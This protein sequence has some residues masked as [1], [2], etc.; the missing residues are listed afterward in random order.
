MPDLWIIFRPTT[1]FI[2]L[3]VIF[4]FSYWIASNI[5]EATDENPTHAPA[6]TPQ[7]KVGNFEWQRNR[8]A[9]KR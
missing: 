8:D 9:Q 6:A 1:G 3:A 4:S 2:L 5:D 7:V